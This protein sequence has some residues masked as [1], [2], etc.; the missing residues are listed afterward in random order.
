MPTQ[1]K[2]GAKGDLRECPGVDY[3]FRRL[4]CPEFLT[5]GSQTIY[6]TIE[7]S[8]PGFEGLSSPEVS[9][10]ELVNRFCS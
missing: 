4:K 5:P 1:L 7:R 9:V 3:V 2:D 8:A 10:L 6:G